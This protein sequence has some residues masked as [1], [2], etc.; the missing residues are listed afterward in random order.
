MQRR[1]CPR[2]SPAEPR[3]DGASE[4]NCAYRRPRYGIARLRRS[5][6]G[7]RAVG[8][9]G[10]SL[11]CPGRGNPEG[12]CVPPPRGG[13]TGRTGCAAVPG[14]TVPLSCAAPCPGPAGLH[15]AGGTRPRSGAVVAAHHPAECGGVPGEAGSP[16]TRLETRTK[17]VCHRRERQTSLVLGQ[18]AVAAAER[19]PLGGAA[20]G[21]TRRLRR[22]VKANVVSCAHGRTTPGP[23]PDAAVTAA[24]PGRAR[25]SHRILLVDWTGLRVRAPVTGPERW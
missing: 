14:G 17:G 8:C 7:Q 13:P 9:L 3:G 15:C 5:P 11:R 18:D 20:P 23:P 12:P 2:S 4:W 6:T 19:A 21:G 25:N 16:A 10:G 24:H 22:V 1:R